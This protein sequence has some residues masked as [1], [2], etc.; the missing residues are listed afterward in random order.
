VPVH[1]WGPAVPGAAAVT[2]MASVSPR[3][4]SSSGPAPRAQ[5]TAFTFSVLPAMVF[6]TQ[7]CPWVPDRATLPSAMKPVSVTLA[8]HALF[9]L[10]VG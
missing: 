3:Y 7:C 9:A 10:F 8:E 5:F 4:S 2:L 1:V 6:T